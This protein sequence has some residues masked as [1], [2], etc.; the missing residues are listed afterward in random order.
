VK[1]HRI[2]SILLLMSSG[3]TAQLSPAEALHRSRQAQYAHHF[4][5]A[6]AYAQSA[7]TGYLNSSQPD[8]LGEAYVM[9][10]SSSSL[11]GLGYSER[12]PILEKSRQAFEQ[13]GNR[14]RL[15]D[16]LT[17]EAELYN[18]TDSAPAALHMALQALQLYQTV[19]YPKQQAI[20]NLLTSIC[21]VLGDY[22]EAIRYGLLSIHTAAATGD[23]SA[24]M[25]A[26]YNHLAVS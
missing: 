14:K 23:T 17:D 13:A 9:Q 16:V 12:I 2:I 11:A 26:Y 15:A 19:G 1:I 6:K 24:S 4:E 25:S 7:I 5:E 21:I 20:Y 3:V 18:L 22:N 10:W 8:S